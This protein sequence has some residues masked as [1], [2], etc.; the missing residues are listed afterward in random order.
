MKIVP[1]EGFSLTKI[2]GINFLVPTRKASEHCWV[3]VPVSIFELMCWE[4]LSK[5][6]TEKE[7]CAIT[8]RAFRRKPEEAEKI[9]SAAVN[10]LL[11][12]GCLVK[13]GEGEGL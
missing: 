12:K 11:S 4:G 6:K 3:I 2:C 5:G 13:V 7:L 10:T 8:E 9:I 1:R